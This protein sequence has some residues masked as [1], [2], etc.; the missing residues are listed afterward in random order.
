MIANKKEFGLGVGLMVGFWTLFVIFMSPIFSGQNLLDYMDNLYNS[1]SKSSSYY[2]P[3]AAEKATAS[4]GTAVTATIKASD[5]A[6]AQRMT[7]LLQSAQA[8]VTPDG[9]NLKVT[10]D[11]GT[12]LNTMVADSDLMFKN[13]GTAVSAKYGGMEPKLALYEWYNISKSMQKG[14]EKEENIKGYNTVYSIMS[15][16]IEPAYNYYGVQSKNIKENLGTVVISLVGYVVYTLWF[17]F[18]I[19]FMFEGF[20]LRLDH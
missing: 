6:Q 14:F 5:A 12:I 16:A 1:I 11:M 9:N 18:A 13:N 20:G 3:K 19:L 4:Q 8:T 2:I 7:T 15:K 10:G 17:G